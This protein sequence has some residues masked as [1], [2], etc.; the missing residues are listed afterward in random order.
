MNSKELIREHWFSR[1]NIPQVVDHVLT[2]PT[3]WR[4]GLVCIQACEICP[5]AQRGC[6][7]TCVRF[8][9][10]VC[11]TCP[12]TAHPAAGKIQYDISTK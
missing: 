7:K 4:V 10:K 6:A 12:C 8:P 3:K 11:R 1:E 2:K 9:D 5:L